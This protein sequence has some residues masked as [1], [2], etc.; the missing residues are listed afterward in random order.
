MIV[1][2]DERCEECSDIQ[3][4]VD[5]LKDIFIDVNLTEYDYSS[6]EGKE[7]YESTGITYLPAIL[8]DDTVSSSEG[9]S[10]VQTFLDTAGRLLLFEDRSKL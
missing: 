2:N 7:L 3:Q 5:S 10:N 8:F 1:L 9:F 6:E 4:L